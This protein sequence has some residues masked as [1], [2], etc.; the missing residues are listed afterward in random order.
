MPTILYLG[1]HTLHRTI[2]PAAK[3]E[4]WCG[5]SMTHNFSPDHTYFIQSQFCLQ[6]LI[7]CPSLSPTPEV[8]THTIK[9]F[10]IGISSIHGCKVPNDY[11]ITAC[12]SDGDRPLAVCGSQKL[13]KIFDT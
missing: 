9:Y 11:N 6:S 4:W 8:E 5:L 7:Y 10:Y 13:S 1:C 2:R 3:K 12:E